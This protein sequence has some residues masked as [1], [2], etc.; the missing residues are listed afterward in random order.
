VLAEDLNQT[1]NQVRCAC[2]CLSKVGALNLCFGDGARTLYTNVA[3]MTVFR[4]CLTLRSFPPCYVH[5][6]YRTV[7]AP[8]TRHNCRADLLL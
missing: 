4:H 2:V 6:F 1:L 8:L 7:A 5:L 3:Q